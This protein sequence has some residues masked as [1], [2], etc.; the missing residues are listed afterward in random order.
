MKMHPPFF[1]FSSLN[2]FIATFKSFDDNVI[3]NC[4][5]PLWSGLL[6]LLDYK[7]I[8]WS[9]LWYIYY[10]IHWTLVMTR[11][12]DFWTFSHICIY[13]IH[14]MSTFVRVLSIV[15]QWGGIYGLPLL[16]RNGLLRWRLLLSGTR[17]VR[18]CT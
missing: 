14:K 9:I 16:N 11:H 15:E 17:Y 3:L 12:V 2:S 10:I 13:F 18:K 6:K 7:I 1:A 8:A 4:S 5:S